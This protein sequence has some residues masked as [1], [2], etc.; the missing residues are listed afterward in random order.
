M[1]YAVFEG[2][3]VPFNSKTK[4][5]FTTIRM[6]EQQLLTD[7]N[8]RHRKCSC[9]DSIIMKIDNHTTKII[10]EQAMAPTFTVDSA[11][12]LHTRTLVAAVFK[13]NVAMTIMLAR[14][15]LA[16]IYIS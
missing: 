2:W 6:S 15:R 14:I 3:R 12:I 13:V 16:E 1:F 9:N 5:M 4:F 10:V 7:D 8:Q 11:V